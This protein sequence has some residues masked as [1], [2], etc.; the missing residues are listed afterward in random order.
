M[1][2]IAELRAATWPTPALG[3]GDTPV[4]RVKNMANP[5]LTRPSIVFVP[6]P[7]G[8]VEEGVP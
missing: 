3:P 2:P 1:G 6:H 5:A 7:K 4:G 8:K